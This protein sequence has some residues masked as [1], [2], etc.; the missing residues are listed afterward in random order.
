[1]TEQVSE[2]HDGVLSILYEVWLGTVT[3]VLDN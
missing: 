2:S 3:D 1:V